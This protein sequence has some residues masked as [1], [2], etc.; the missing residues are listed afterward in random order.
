MGLSK[1]DYFCSMILSCPALTLWNKTLPNIT[2]NNMYNL[3]VNY[4]PSLPYIYIFILAWSA[5]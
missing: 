3:T 2:Q 1:M 5:P 4:A